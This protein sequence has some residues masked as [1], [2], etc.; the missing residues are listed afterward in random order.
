MQFTYNVK[1]KSKSKLIYDLSQEK[2]SKKQLRQH[3]SIKILSL[4]FLKKSTFSS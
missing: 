3:I 1:Y 2:S 4:V